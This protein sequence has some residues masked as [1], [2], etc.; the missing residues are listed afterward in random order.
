MEGDPSPLRMPRFLFIGVAGML[1]AAP[2]AAQ[3]D[4]IIPGPPADEYVDVTGDGIADLLITSRTVRVQDPQQ[5]GLRGWYKVGVRT[6]SGTAVLMWSTPSTQRWYTLEDSTQLDSGLLAQ[7]IHFK[8]LSWTDED[9]PTEFWL[10]E[11]PFGPAIGAAEDGWYGTGNHYEGSMVLRSA[12]E[13]GTSLAAFAFEL[14]YPYGSVAI[15]VKH[16][17]RV[18]IGFGSEGDPTR[19]ASPIKDE[20]DFDFEKNGPQ[21]QVP[22][23]IP[24]DELVD[25]TSDDSPDLVITG[26][27]AADHGSGAPQGTYHRGVRLL[28]GT[29]LLMVKRTDGTYVPFTLRD[30]QEIDPERVRKLIAED[31]YR[32][33]EAPEWPVF[34]DALTQRYGSAS[35]AEGPMGW[36]PAEDAV[37]GAFVFRA[38]QYGRPMIGSYEVMSTAPGGE[39]G[40]R[41]GSLMDY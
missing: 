15:A 40:V 9:R 41:L 16:T 8:Q 7:R 35:T 32:W 13:R 27:N 23:G 20:P 6:L 26:I 12:N 28:S 5:P 11:R 18:P 36:Q 17:V 22:P 2:A 25:L 33:A 30:A 1:F 3:D 34:I 39:L 4:R 24:P 37:D 31:H 19:A 21:A 10:L 29:A 38:T 14:P